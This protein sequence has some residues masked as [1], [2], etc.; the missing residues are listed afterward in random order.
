M[1]PAAL[2]A[3]VALLLAAT[4][5]LAEDDAAAQ[6]T[7]TALEKQSWAAWQGHDGSFFQRVLSEDHLDIHD[8]GISNKK[9]VVAGVASGVCV[10]KTWDVGEMKF[11]RVSEDTAMLF[12]RASQDTHCGAA[13]V[14]SPVLVTSLYVKRDGQ[15]L[16]LLYEQVPIH[17]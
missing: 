15:W 11:T 13:V 1:K 9:Q 14:P 4:P 16:N 17:A 6:G 7:V 2:V 5:A 10:V 12:Y 8:S 3:L